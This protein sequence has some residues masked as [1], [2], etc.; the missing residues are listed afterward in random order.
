MLLGPRQVGKTTLA[1]ELLKSYD[2]I[3][4]DLELPSDLAVGRLEVVMRAKVTMRH[5]VEATVLGIPKNEHRYYSPPNPCFAPR[6]SF[7][8]GVV[9]TY[10]T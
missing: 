5:S 10:D 6:L 1:N 8:S 7:S 4:V 2:S 3:Y 9:I